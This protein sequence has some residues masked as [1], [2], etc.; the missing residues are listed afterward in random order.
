MTGTGMF[1]DSIDNA[2]R[3]FRSELADRVA[4]L[5]HDELLVVGVASADTSVLATT[6]DFWGSNDVLVAIAQSAGLGADDELLDVA[7]TLGWVHADEDGPNSV[8]VEA[9]V[10]EVDRVAA[11]AVDF[12]RA[13]AGVAH[14][15][16]V[17]GH[18]ADGPV[19]L[20][21]EATAVPIEPAGPPPPV[22]EFPADQDEL[23][24]A[25]SRA[26]H[27]KYG[28]TPTVDEAG[29]FVV[30]VG[31]LPAFVLP[32]P[33]SPQVRILVPLATG[34]TG[35]TRVAEVLTELNSGYAFIRLIL[36]DDQVN[37]V[38]DLPAAP[39]SAMQLSTQLDCMSQFLDTIDEAFALRLG[40]Q[41]VGDDS[42]DAADSELPA[43]LLTLLHLDPNGTGELDAEQVATVCGYDRDTI[44]EYLDLAEE[45]TIA[46]EES[47]GQARDQGDTDEAGA[48][49]H[50]ADGWR[51]T[52]QSLRAALRVVTLGV[53]RTSR[54]LEPYNPFPD[55]P[56]LFE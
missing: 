24:A 6:I 34:I 45:Q 18:S 33:D 22:F 14:P 52:V 9:P 13:V 7:A 51:H 28:I 15:C 21:P 4:S 17:R 56:D 53:P 20:S 46:W 2:W 12:L 3:R 55:Q 19:E 8:R 26:L 50:E 49:E 1:D 27:W 10:R 25:V 36:D 48:C 44:L 5:D 37:A 42:G 39:F 11:L 29:D 54:Q 23:C 38:I 43:G 32:G 30:S 31:A 41:L 16:F 47:A 35:R 40:G